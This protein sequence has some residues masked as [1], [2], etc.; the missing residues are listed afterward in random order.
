MSIVL[1]WVIWYASV[2]WSFV[3]YSVVNSCSVN[4]SLSFISFGP[5]FNIIELKCVHS[6]IPPSK[7]KCK[8]YL[9][10]DKLQYIYRTV[11]ARTRV[12]PSAHLIF[13]RCETKEI[14]IISLNLKYKLKSQHNWVKCA[15]SYCFVR[16]NEFNG[17]WKTK[18]N[19]SLSLSYFTYG[20]DC[21]QAVNSM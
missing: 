20:S 13:N 12:V 5:L 3:C 6:V 15:F 8:S 10:C 17:Q 1:R 4:F 16:S 18:L 11:S 2:G 21:A 14:I 9:D 7:C 19:P